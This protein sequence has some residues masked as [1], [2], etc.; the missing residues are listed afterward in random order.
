MRAW[1]PKDEHRRSRRS[2]RQL[3][4]RIAPPPPPPPAPPAAPPT[5]NLHYEA[6]WSDSWSFRRCFHEHKTVLEAAACAKPNG[7]GWYVIGVENGEPRPL[8]YGE[9][10][11]VDRFRFGAR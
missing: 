10:A 8:W 7:C 6:A 11:I 9:N 4:T 2:K 1:A 3:K 5:P